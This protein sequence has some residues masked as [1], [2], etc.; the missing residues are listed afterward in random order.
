MQRYDN[1]RKQFNQLSWQDSLS[2]CL[3]ACCTTV[4][5]A[6]AHARAHTDLFAA[7]L[8]RFV[9]SLPLLPPSPPPPPPPSISFKIIDT[10]GKFTTSSAVYLFIAA[11]H[12]TNAYNVCTFIVLF[13]LSSRSIDNIFCLEI[14]SS[15]RVRLSHITL[16][17][18]ALILKF[19]ICYCSMILMYGMAW[20]GTKYWRSLSCTR[21]RHSI[22]HN[23]LIA[24]RSQQNINR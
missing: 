2:H 14:L 24:F 12:S 16:L 15:E 21:C 8:S 23:Q 1:K 18:H 9:T 17:Y 13:F 19:V 3:F 11:A 22:S 5:Y 20:H 10:H 4:I 7:I 6:H